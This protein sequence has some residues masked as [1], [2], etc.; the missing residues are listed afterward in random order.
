MKLSPNRPTGQRL[1][2]TRRSTA[3][4]AW[5]IVQF[6]LWAATGVVALLLDFTMP[7][8]FS[9]NA[10]YVLVI[11]GSAIVRVGTPLVWAAACTVLS[12]LAPVFAPPGL[13]LAWEI[14]DRALTIAVLWL[15]ALLVRQFQRE[16]AAAQA[17]RREAEAATMRKSRFLAAASHD[18]RQP[19]QSL[20]LFA[21]LLKQKA[22]GSD[23]ERVAEPLDEAVK[24]LNAMLSSLLELSRLD[25]GVLQPRPVAVDVHEMMRRLALAYRMETAA[26]GLSFRTRIGA[27]LTLRTDPELLERILRNLLDNALKY[28]ERGGILLAARRRADGIRFDVI[29]TGPGIPVEQHEAVFEEFFQLDNV[30]RDRSKGLGVGLS[31]VE[32]AVALLGGRVVLASRPGHGARFTVILPDRG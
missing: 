18:L 26:K 23:L 16:R 1:A 12:L 24:A 19:A 21:T 27:G 28:T 20:V 10:L 17:A 29:D 32:R 11:I 31:V 14:G 5:R 25:A 30:E 22:A 9:G 8:G 13:G 7:D 2:R 3:W 15:T 4:T 6:A